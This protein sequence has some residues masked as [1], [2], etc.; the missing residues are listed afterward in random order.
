[1]TN[2][3]SSRTSPDRTW[4]PWSA[5]LA[6]LFGLP[7]SDDQLA[8]YRRP[9]GPPD[10]ANGPLLRGQCGGRT[11]RRKVAPPQPCS[12]SI[13]PPSATTTN[14]LAPGE[15]VTI[16][17]IAADRAQARI[18]MRYVNGLLQ[19]VPMLRAMIEER[20]SETIT[21]SNRTVIEIRTA[22]FRSTR[23]YSYGAVLCDEVAFWRGD[24]D[25]SANPDSEILRAIRPGL[26]SIPGSMLILASSPYRRT[27][28]LWDSYQRHYGRDDAR[29][30]IW[31][32]ASAE[33]NPTLDP[34]II[35]EAYED[36]PESAAAEYGGQFR[37]DISDFITRAVVEACIERG[38]SNARQRARLGSV[39]SRLL[40]RQAAAAA[41]A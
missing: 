38:A 36:D 30:L 41:T 19:A 9:H 5:F 1:M 31:Q 37:S 27:G 25:S 40:T 3:C 7:L 12:R 10:G 11:P 20:T 24:D 22:S 29:V 8:L 16:G 39:T 2:S 35:A 17:L 23:G 21:L 26:S 28:S 4:R 32:A 34:A 18:L 14:I 6:A 13:S 33:M 15:K